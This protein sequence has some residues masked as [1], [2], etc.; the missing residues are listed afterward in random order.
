MSAISTQGIEMESVENILLMDKIKSAKLKFIEEIEECPHLRK[1]N[2]CSLC[3]E[4]MPYFFYRR[5]SLRNRYLYEQLTE[6]KECLEQIE[7]MAAYKYAASLSPDFQL[8]K[9]C[10]DDA[11]KKVVKLLDKVILEAEDSDDPEA[12]LNEKFSKTLLNISP[13]DKEQG[14]QET[15]SQPLIYEYESNV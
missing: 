15:E 1:K 14:A 7:S 2:C 13:P 4:F 8:N 6:K 11:V 12:F 10:T 3:A 9:L 5:I